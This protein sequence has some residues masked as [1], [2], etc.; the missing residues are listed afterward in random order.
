MC[1]KS[2]EWHKF[3]SRLPTC[4]RKEKGLP[5]GKVVSSEERNR[6]FEACT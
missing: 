4:M 2:K 5:E 3:E 6:A 1:L